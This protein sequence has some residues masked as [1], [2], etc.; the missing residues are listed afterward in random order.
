MPPLLG[1]LIGGPFFPYWLFES[2]RF[3]PTLS[4]QLGYGLE[5]VGLLEPRPTLTRSPF[6]N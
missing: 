2:E 6:R 1:P 3:E 5:L 4:F